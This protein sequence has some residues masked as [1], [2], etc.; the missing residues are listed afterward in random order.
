MLLLTAIITLVNRFYFSKF[1]EKVKKGEKSI[2][3]ELTTEKQNDIIDD[4]VSDNEENV[5]GISY[6]KAKLYFIRLNDRT[7][8]MYLSAVYRKFKS[9]DLQLKNVLNH[10]VKGPYPEEKRKGFMTAI[11]ADLL[12]G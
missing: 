3:A 11:P 9:D 1:N 12:L 7:E 8:K 4:K 10:L 6:K 2:I 5:K